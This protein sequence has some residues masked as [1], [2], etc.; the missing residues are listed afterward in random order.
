MNVNDWA[1]QNYKPLLV[2]CKNIT[3]N[4]ELSEE[5]LH[6]S[7]EVLLTKP[8]VQHIVESGGAY[9]Y[10]LRIILNNWKSTTSPFFKIYRKN[11]EQ[12]ELE[13]YLEKNDI[14]DTSHEQQ[15][16]EDT[17]SYIKQELRKLYWYDQQVFDLY[18][19]AGSVMSVARATNI[20][21]TSLSLTINRVKNH[22]KSKIKDA[23]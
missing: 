14:P 4:N 20:P 1:T 23:P 22:I 11:F 15:E 12:V 5:L 2:A 21:R 6:Y 7:L 13:S 10:T 17:A 3:A 8:N 9:F 19:E 16:I 18:L